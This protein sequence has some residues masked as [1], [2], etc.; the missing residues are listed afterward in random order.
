MNLNSANRQARDTS[1]PLATVII[2]NFN[3]GSLVLDAVRSA[4]NQSIGARLEVLVVDN[5]SR[6]GS[7]KA[8][9]NEFGPRVRVLRQ[10]T[11]LGFTGGN[12]VGFREGRGRYFLLLN[13][14]AVADP[15]W[16]E[17]LLARLEEDE[18]LGMC[19]PKILCLN[20]PELLD[21]A[22]HGLFIDGLNRS[23]GHLKPDGPRW[24]QECEVLF[25]SGCA[26]AYRASAV[27][28]AGGFCEDFFAYGD[29]ADLGLHLRLM[30]FSCRYVPAA[31][32]WHEQSGTSRPFSCQKIFWIE[33]NRLWVLWRFLPASWVL[34]SP[35][36]TLVRIFGALIAGIR[37][38][39]VAGK[40]LEGSSGV[41]IAGTLICAWCAA[42]LRLPR[43]LSER[44]EL[45]TRARISPAA[46]YRLLN[47]FRVPA[48][49][50]MFQ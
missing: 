47:R 26:A 25:A 31:K 48:R 17:S 50:M 19:T 21:N 49:E 11:N 39:G 12:N 1:F 6:D 27:Q 9:E 45:K 40:V 28:A 23:I 15:Q 29:D 10:T 33:R 42:L 43:C 22:G 3:G 30:G 24:N 7:E 37:G 46:W 14:D 18:T 2:V 36:F 8:I 44:Y 35:C 13:N 32:V 41:A 38:Q 34:L 4:L 20:A 5:A 16:A